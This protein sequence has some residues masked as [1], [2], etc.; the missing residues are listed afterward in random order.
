MFG[1]VGVAYVL[2]VS[3]LKIVVSVFSDFRNLAITPSYNSV[4]Y[5]YPVRN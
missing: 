2:R 1:L 5:E 4:V 3:D